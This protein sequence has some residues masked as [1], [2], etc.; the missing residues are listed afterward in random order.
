MVSH[1]KSIRR[2]Q[3]RSYKHSTDIAR[4]IEKIANNCSECFPQKMINSF[5]RRS[6][7]R[8][9]MQHSC[10]TRNKNLESETFQRREWIRN[11]IQIEPMFT[12]QCHWE[13]KATIKTSTTNRTSNTAKT[14]SGWFWATTPLGLHRKEVIFCHPD[15]ARMCSQRSKSRRNKRKTFVNILERIIDWFKMSEHGT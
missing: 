7:S 10:H 8:R 14:W 15:R 13:T 2:G 1:T 11:Y 4:L 3:N 6:R 12:R 9:D 5:L